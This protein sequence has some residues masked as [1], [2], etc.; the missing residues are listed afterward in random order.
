M[1]QTV[2]PLLKMLKGA[3]KMIFIPI[4]PGLDSS[5]EPFGRQAG[6]KE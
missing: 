4:V 3:F 2:I 6:I 1:W 5:L